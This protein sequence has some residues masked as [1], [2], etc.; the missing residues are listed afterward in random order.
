MF[1]SGKLI[2]FQIAFSGDGLD[3]HRSF[4]GL[5]WNGENI[6]PKELKKVLLRR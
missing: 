5:V 2:K 6:L 4:V 1:Y 3:R